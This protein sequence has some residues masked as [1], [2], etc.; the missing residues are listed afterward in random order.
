MIACGEQAETGEGRSGGGHGTPHG[1]AEGSGSR[2]MRAGSCDTLRG[3]SGVSWNLGDT[4][5]TARSPELL[6]KGSPGV[7][8]W[9]LRAPPAL[10]SLRLVPDG[11][12]KAPVQ[13]KRG[14]REGH[15]CFVTVAEGSMQAQALRDP[16]FLQ[17]ISPAGASKALGVWEGPCLG[18]MRGS[19]CPHSWGSAT[20]TQ[21]GRQ[22]AKS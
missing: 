14:K 7:S 17:T 9:V 13:S 1:A 10:Q 18:N 2:A 11:E 15:T 12:G 21:V 3:P 20:E 6:G 19:S 4:A 16:T 22:A 5:S 8:S